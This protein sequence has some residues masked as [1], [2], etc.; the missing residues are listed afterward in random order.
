MAE[1]YRFFNS[2]VGDIR[3]Y[4]AD[5]FAEYFAQFL[6]NG[7]YEANGDMG[8]N[9]T[10]NGLQANVSAGYAFLRGR[11]YKNTSVLNFTLDPADTQLGRIDRLVVKLDLIGRRI[12][13][14]LKKGALGS[15]PEAPALIDSADVLEI[16]LAKIQI[17]AKSTTGIIIDERIP[18]VSLI[19]IQLDVVKQD[20]VLNALT[21]TTAG[22]V[23]DARQGK[24]LA[25]SINTKAETATYQSQLSASNWLGSTA[26]FTQEVT[27]SGIKTDDNPI[28]DLRSSGVFSTDI[29]AIDSWG[30]VYKITTSS[31]KIKAYAKKIPA[32]DILLQLKVVR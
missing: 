29:E 23:L 6:S 22:K 24:V 17:N 32:T 21:Q 15:S 10:I 18:V 28:V 27:I 16:P 19:S 7:V 3:E 8:L 31:N 26:P 5:D 13:T 11:L 4:P 12:S 30:E 1:E 14:V 20:D 2:E 9:V 25:D